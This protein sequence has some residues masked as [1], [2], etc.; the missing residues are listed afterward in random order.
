MSKMCANRTEVCACSG[1]SSKLQTLP[2]GGGFGAHKLWSTS[3]A[4]GGNWIQHQ[5]DGGD[6][7]PEAAS[8]A[9]VL[10]HSRLSSL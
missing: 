3:L 9:A 2:G 6:G 1:P 7:R 5:S 10:P 4:V 8:R